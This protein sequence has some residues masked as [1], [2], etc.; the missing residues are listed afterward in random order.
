MPPGQL[1][2]V[3]VAADPRE[4]NRVNT[5]HLRSREHHLEQTWAAGATLRARPSWKAADPRPGSSSELGALPP[6]R[7]PATRPVGTAQRPSSRETR[8][9]ICV[10]SLTAAPAAGPGRPLFSTELFGAHL[11]DLSAFIPITGVPPAGATHLAACP[12]APVT[13]TVHRVTTQVKGAN[14]GLDYQ[15][16]CD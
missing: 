3:L 6:C 16:S 11:S 5:A 8:S 4:R 15:G 12:A 7:P 2:A 1:K 10:T 9:A 13:V 14:D